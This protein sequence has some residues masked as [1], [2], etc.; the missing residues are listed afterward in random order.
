MDVRS[1]V[2]AAAI[3]FL[4]AACSTFTEG[5][6]SPPLIAERPDSLR[7]AFLTSA[8]SRG[9]GE[10][11]LMTADLEVRDGC[12][13][14]AS[15]GTWVPIWPKGYELRQSPA[16]W[17]VVDAKG[18]SVAYVGGVARVVG[19]EMNPVEVVGGSRKA[20]QWASELIGEP[21]PKKCAGGKYWLV[22]SEPYPSDL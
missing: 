3:A 19:G 11:A 16:G 22:S 2:G 15:G 8:A 12:L 17:E 1:L 10:Q 13:V 21:V 6:P 18:R 20:D 7:P 4:A 9:V 14:F 5:T